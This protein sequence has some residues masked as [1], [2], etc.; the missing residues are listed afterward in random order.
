MRATLWKL[1]SMPSPRT[2]MMHLICMV[3]PSR[4]QKCSR[5][6]AEMTKIYHKW[7]HRF[8]IEVPK[9]FKIMNGD[10]VIPPTYQE[11]YCHMVFDIN[12]DDLRCNVRF[13]AD[14]HTTDTHHAMTYASVVLQESV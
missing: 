14:S 10:E 5:I 11:M 3:G 6:I 13:V 4:A 2:C 8:G 12:M 7:N 1:M 9:N